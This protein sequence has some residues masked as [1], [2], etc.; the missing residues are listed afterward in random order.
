MLLANSEH[1]ARYVAVGAWVSYWALTPEVLQKIKNEVK[2][3]GW[4]KVQKY[5]NAPPEELGRKKGLRKELYPRFESGGGYR[6]RSAGSNCKWEVTPGCNMVFNLD[7]SESH[8]G[9]DSGRT[10]MSIYQGKFAA[11]DPSHQSERI[12][13]AYAT[14][15]CLRRSSTDS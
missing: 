10:H 14:L 11:E 8:A 5:V 7:V 13:S 4:T 12:P 2:Q 1:W 15:S 9:A 3:E 6:H